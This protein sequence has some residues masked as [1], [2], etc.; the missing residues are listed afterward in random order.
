MRKEMSTPDVPQRSTVSNNRAFLPV[1][2]QHFMWA[3]NFPRAPLQVS[4]AELRKRFEDWEREWETNKEYF[5]QLRTIV[6]ATVLPSNAAKIV[7]FGCGTVPVPSLISMTRSTDSVQTALM[8][9]FRDRLSAGQSHD[10]PCFVQDH[11]YLNIGMDRHPMEGA[12]ILDDP[13]GFLEVDETTIV[14]AIR[15]NIPVRQII[16]DIARPAV[17]IWRALN[18]H[19]PETEKYVYV[20]RCNSGISSD[21]MTVMTPAPCACNA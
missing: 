17:M 3:K 19:E 12:K 11:G 21:R 14:L 2:V 9:M 15:P 6:E 13:R 1:T 16:A 10:V 4:M 8:C 20:L 5:D 7:A 18:D